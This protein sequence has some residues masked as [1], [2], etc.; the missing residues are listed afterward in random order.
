[1]PLVLADDH[2]VARPLGAEGP[3]AGA[4]ARPLRVG[5]VNLMPR[6]ETYEPILLGPLARA[7][8]AVEPVFL[9]LRSHGYRSSDPAHLARFYRP[10][11]EV[12]SDGP[13]DGLILTGAPVETLPFADVRYWPEL[14]S[15]LLDARARVRSTLGICWGGLALAELLGVRKV[16]YPKKLFG[17]FEDVPVGGGALAGDAPFSCA[18]SRH[19]GIE[20]AELERAAARGD[21]RPLSHGTETGYSLFESS[22][23]RWVA[24]LGHPE[25]DAAR[26]AYEWERDRALG[27]ADV[28]PPRNFDGATSSGDW[29]RHADEL[30]GRWVSGLAA[31]A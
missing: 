31:A 2:P 7:G 12:F 19:A 18:H 22:D 24:H 9:R 20:D 14:S 17:V 11:D 26:I 25:Y 27:R 23:G 16:N 6:L 10:W 5:I 4:G 29:A 21:V 28:E 15:L 13:P 1:M 8:L 3:S 30:F